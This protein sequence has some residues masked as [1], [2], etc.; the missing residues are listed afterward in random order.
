[1]KGNH[2]AYIKKDLDQMPYLH[3]QE[4]MERRK[5]GQVRKNNLDLKVLKKKIQIEQ[6]NQPF[7]GKKLQNYLKEPLQANMANTGKEEKSAPKKSL[8]MI[9]APINI[10]LSLEAGQN[11]QQR[12]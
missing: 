11:S 5:L 10:K 4:F 9:N 12:K 7:Q 8:P 3:S 2:Q 6:N 1:M